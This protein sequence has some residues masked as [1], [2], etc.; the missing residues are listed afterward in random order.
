MILAICVDLRTALLSK[1]ANFR[2]AA[3]LTICPAVHKRRS[4]EQLKA[5]GNTGSNLLW[6][7]V[8]RVTGYIFI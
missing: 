7:T 4:R 8:A 3:K 6:A 2:A 1:Y 5:Q